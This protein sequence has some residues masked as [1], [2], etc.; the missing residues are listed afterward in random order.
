VFWCCHP[1]S[2]KMVQN[3][4]K[5]TYIHICIH[6]F[7]HLHI[8]IYVF[9][10]IDTYVCTHKRIFIYIHLV[11][12]IYTYTVFWCC[13]PV[14]MRMVQNRNIFKSQPKH[15]RYVHICLYIWIYTYVIYV[16]ITYIHIILSRNV[17][18][19]CLYLY[20]FKSQP[21]HTRYVHICLYVQTYL[22]IHIYL[23][24]II[25]INKH[26]A[27]YHNHNYYYRINIHTNDS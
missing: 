21:K 8:W 23:H 2:M 24:A 20:I 17:C 26:V 11:I 18:M 22:N 10:S 9:T 14:S 13:H 4:N 5:H 1:V 25:C 7:I 12:N 27:D 15:T 6:V 19:S 3:R 16:Y